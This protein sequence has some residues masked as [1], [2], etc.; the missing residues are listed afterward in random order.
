MIAWKNSFREVSDLLKVKHW[1]QIETQI[2][3]LWLVESNAFSVSLF[4]SRLE[5]EHSDESKLVAVSLL[6][7]GL[8]WGEGREASK[9]DNVKTKGCMLNFNDIHLETRVDGT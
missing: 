2:Q 8:E 7:K 1:S 9:R 6:W 4:V 3:I 5:T